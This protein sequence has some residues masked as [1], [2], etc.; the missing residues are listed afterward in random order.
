MGV[1]IPRLGVELEPQLPTYA[2][3]T[4]TWDPS[5]VCDLHHSSRCHQIPNPLSEARDQTLVFFFFFQF[6]FILFHFLITQ[7]NLSHLYQTLVF[8][9]TSWICFCCATTVTPNGVYFKTI[10][11]AQLCFDAR[12]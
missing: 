2:T 12:L 1:P 4:G 6:Y 7:M 10:F 9:V 11:V 5:C 3:V 8:M